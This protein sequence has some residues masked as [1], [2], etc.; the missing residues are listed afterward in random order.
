MKK[1]LPA[2]LIG[3]VFLAGICV[4]LY[5]LASDLLS[6]WTATSSIRTYVQK[7][8]DMDDSARLKELAAAREYNS[9]LA[10]GED[11]V[12]QKGD[13]EGG[14]TIDGEWLSRV[15]ILNEGAMIGYLKIP[16]IDVYLPI[17][18]GTSQAALEDGVGHI[19]NTSLPVGGS[20]TH[21]VLSGHTGLPTGELLTDLDQLSVGDEFYLYTLGEVL[22]YRVDQIKTVLPTETDDLQIVPGGDYVTLLTCTPYGINTH[23][24]LVRGTRVETVTQDAEAQAMR[25]ASAQSE[26][27]MIPGYALAAA[28]GVWLLLKALFRRF[29]KYD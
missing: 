14:E 28:A 6:R 24:L 12:Y 22:K 17:Y 18:Q 9:A 23:R 21:A 15:E 26:L 29:R 19:E 4:L 13:G 3:F 20:G 25:H 11:G 8:A 5:P 2:F 7:V 16:K 10:R 27:T 1:K